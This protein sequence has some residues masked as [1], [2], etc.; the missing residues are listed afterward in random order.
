MRIRRRR[1]RG[2]RASESVLYFL[3]FWDFLGC[4]FTDY[5]KVNGVGSSSGN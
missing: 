2:V 4:L 1:K 5:E 3:C